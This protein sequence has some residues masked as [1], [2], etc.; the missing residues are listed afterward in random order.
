MSK[1]WKI[2]YCRQ[3]VRAQHYKGSRICKDEC[4]IRLAWNGMTFPGFLFL[5]PRIQ[6][7]IDSRQALFSSST[8]GVH[9]RFR[10]FSRY[11]VASP[12]T[13]RL[14]WLC[15]TC[16]HSI[17]APLIWT[18]TSCRTSLH[19]SVLHVS[20]LY[21]TMVVAVA[22]GLSSPPSGRVICKDGEIHLEQLAHMLEFLGWTSRCLD[23][24]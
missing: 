10:R 21:C 4:P 17:A 19:V 18:V 23:S 5:V 12:N 1:A 14:H 11:A 24:T 8:V 3:L 15:W 13:R 20:A 16:G 2:D 6:Q 22:Y 9:L 7:A